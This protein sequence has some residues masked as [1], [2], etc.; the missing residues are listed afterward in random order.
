[1]LLDKYHMGRDVIAKFTK[2]PPYAWIVPQDQWDPPTAARFMSKMQLLGTEVYAAE[3][4]FTADGVSYGEGTWIIPMQQPFAYFVKNVFEEQSYPDLTKYPDL[5]EGLVSPTTFK[6]S[7]LPPY[8]IGGWTLPYQM[9]IKSLPVN[10]VLDVPM[11]TGREG[12]GR[13]GEGGQGRGW[14]AL[15]LAEGQQQLHGRQPDPQG[16]RRGGAGARGVH[17]RRRELPGRHLRRDAA[18]D[19][20]RAVRHDLARSWEWR[21]APAARP[22]SRGS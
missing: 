15:D 9:G 10:S 16:R 3:K 20:R 22:R 4:P 21:S 2:E 8:D 1:M 11:R 14:N 17:G 12:R 18:G 13:P 6:D 7:Y 5:W 19:A